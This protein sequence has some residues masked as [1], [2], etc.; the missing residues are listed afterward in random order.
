MGLGLGFGFGLGLGLGLILTLPLTL[1]LTPTRTRC[2]GGS[3]AVSWSPPRPPP[4]PPPRRSAPM[5]LRRPPPPPRLR[6]SRRLSQPRPRTPSLAPGR[7]PLALSRRAFPS[8]RSTARRPPSARQVWPACSSSARAAAECGASR[9][10]KS[11]LSCLV[12][13]STRR[14]KIHT[15][16]VVLVQ[17]RLDV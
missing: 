9:P 11:T 3:L 6:P 2:A 15:I 10:V 14:H 8:R 12:P 5:R 17:R 7:S 16:V 13:P 4:R 1:T